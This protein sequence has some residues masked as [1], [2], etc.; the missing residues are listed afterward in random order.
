MG[1]AKSRK[2]EASVMIG[3]ICLIALSASCN[4]EILKLTKDE[5]KNFP[6]MVGAVASPFG[7]EPLSV[8]GYG[9]VGALPGTGGNIPTGPARSSALRLL[10]RQMDDVPGFLASKEEIGRAHV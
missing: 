4:K 7:L 5:N 8:L 3:F 6:K 9:V 2:V 10:T 1:S